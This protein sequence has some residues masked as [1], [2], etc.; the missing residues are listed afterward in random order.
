MPWQENTR[1]SQRSEFIAFARA[2]GANMSELCRRYEISRK[3][4]YKWLGR[5]MLGSWQASDRS[6]RPSSSPRRTAP[7]IEAHVLALRQRY[8]FYGGRKIRH[9]L[10]REGI[11]SPPAASTITAILDRNGFLSPERRRL[12]NWQR[13][14]AAAPNALWQMD[15]KGHFALTRGRCHPLTVLD[16]HSRFCVCLA[17]CANEQG[18][19]VRSHLTAAFRRYGLPVRMLM[20][21]GPPW[22]S[23]AQGTH[24][25]VSAWLIR[26][27]VSVSHGRPL[28]PQTQGKDERF[29][30]TLQLEL[31]GRRPVWQDNI[32]TQLAFDAY[33]PQYN[34]ER[35]HQALSF[36]VP[37]ARYAPSP[38]T[39]PSV[40]PPIDYDAALEVR[41]VKANGSI[42]FQRRYFFVGKAFAGDPVGLQQ[43]DESVWDV[44]YCHQRVVQIDL[45]LPPTGSEEV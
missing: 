15:F 37:G 26:L 8:P 7:G 44:Y 42:K 35:P 29:H 45:T 18:S 3:T 27:G 22:G 39:F 12:R 9:L 40:L 21:N 43:V 13:F 20:D 23:S 16:D 2:P 1:M 28:H 17:A 14:E 24:T 36:E 4:G 31:I 30:R 19:T 32:Q 11:E 5:A 41:R 34:F 6:R 10:R 25:R 33:R 38:R